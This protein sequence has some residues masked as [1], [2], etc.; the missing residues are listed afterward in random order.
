[1]LRD[2]LRCLS[3]LLWLRSVKDKLKR[4]TTKLGKV[5]LLLIALTCGAWLFVNNA[6]N[7]LDRDFVEKA[8]AAVCWRTTNDYESTIGISELIYIVLLASSIICSSASV[9]KLIIKRSHATLAENKKTAWF[10]ATLSLVILIFIAT[11]FSV[12]QRTT[13]NN[14]NYFLNTATNVVI[15]IGLPT[16]LIVTT[17]AGTYGVY[18]FRRRKN[19]H[20]TIPDLWSCEV[21]LYRY[22]HFKSLTK[23]YLLLVLTLVNKNNII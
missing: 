23:R 15:T 6:Q 13:F 10:L 12:W 17:A 22:S 18:I 3:T 11:V 21:G 16:W 14:N 1:M 2:F 7:C 4:P 5:S 9:S 20:H 8:P 19:W